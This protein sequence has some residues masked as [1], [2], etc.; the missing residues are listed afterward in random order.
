M[1]GSGIDRESKRVSELKIERDG[2]RERVRGRHADGESVCVNVIMCACVDVSFMCL[3]VQVFVL[4]CARD[5]RC[6]QI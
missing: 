1:P 4:V 5:S 3:C 6:I 2:A